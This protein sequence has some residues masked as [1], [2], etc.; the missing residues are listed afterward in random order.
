MWRNI[1]PLSQRNASSMMTGS[2]LFKPLKNGTTLSRFSVFSWLL[3]LCAEDSMVSDGVVFCLFNNLLGSPH[4]HLCSDF[5]GGLFGL[6]SCQVSQLLA[7][8][9]SSVLTPLFYADS[10]FNTSRKQLELL[11]MRYC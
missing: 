4:T 3:L 8:V 2:V 1:W 7:F 10:D 5:G 11:S 6:L 9:S